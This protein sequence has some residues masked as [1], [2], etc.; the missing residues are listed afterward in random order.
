LDPGLPVEAMGV[1]GDDELARFLFA[2]CDA[3]G[4]IRT[5]LRAAPGRATMSD[6]AFNVASN[7]RRT[8]FYHQGVS[9]E[10]TP[11]DFDFAST[12]A[13]ILH[14]GLPGAHRAMDRPWRDDAN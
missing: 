5:A 12:H 11:D 3:R 2:E 1:V 13:R 4:V 10:M 9:A 7:G 8:H 6:D 14:L